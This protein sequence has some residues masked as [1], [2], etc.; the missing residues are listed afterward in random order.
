MILLPQLPELRIQAHDTMPSALFIP[1]ICGV[2]LN[3]QTTKN[4][5]MYL[6][7]VYVFCMGTFIKCVFTRALELIF[8]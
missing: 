6:F 2:Y 4:E 8:N 3:F 7:A 1:N 5:F